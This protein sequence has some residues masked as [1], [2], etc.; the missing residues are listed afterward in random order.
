MGFK[1]VQMTE[2]DE[3]RDYSSQRP[4]RKQ[5]NKHNPG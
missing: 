1:V 2:H 5:R 3:V 4:S